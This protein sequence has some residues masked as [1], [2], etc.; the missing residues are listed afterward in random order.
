VFDKKRKRWGKEGEE[1]G[2]RG[3]RDG[4]EMGKRWGKEGEEK[5]FTVCGLRW[6]VDQDTNNQ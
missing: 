3:G 5:R 6:T 4:E 1:M 2:K